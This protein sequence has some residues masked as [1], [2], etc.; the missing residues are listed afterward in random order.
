MALTRFGRI[1]RETPC[2]LEYNNGD[3]K[4]HTEEVTLRFNSLTTAEIQE[5][6]RTMQARL[7]KDET[8]WLADELVGVLTEIVEADGSVNPVD[9]EL[10]GGLA[11]DNIQAMNTAINEAIRPKEQPA[12]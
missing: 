12:K 8:T 7:K 11:V 3:G 1:L 9:A 2:K 10:L 5:R 6:R 4:I